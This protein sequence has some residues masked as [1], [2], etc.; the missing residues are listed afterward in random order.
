MVHNA[1]YVALVYVHNRSRYRGGAR[2]HGAAAWVSHSAPRYLFV[3]FAFSIVYFAI[4]RGTGAFPVF[5]GF[6][7][8]MLGPLR[9]ND[10]ALS[11]WWG[12]AL[13]HYYLDQR[14]WRIQEDPALREHLGLRPRDTTAG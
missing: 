3:C 5:Q 4:A 9:V 13:H 10:L 2:E 11:M 7:G 6:E 1:Q 12:I 8:A 14:I